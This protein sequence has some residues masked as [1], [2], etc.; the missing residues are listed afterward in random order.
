ME[1]TAIEHG[2]KICNL[3]SK[4]LTHIVVKYS[5][6]EIPQDA[7]EVKNVKVVKQELFWASIQGD[8]RGGSGSSLHKQSTSNTSSLVNQ[9]SRKRRRDTDE[10]DEILPANSLSHAPKRKN[11]DILSENSFPASLPK[12]TMTFPGTRREDSS[13]LEVQLMSQNMKV[14][15]VTAFSPPNAKTVREQVASE[16]LQTEQNY[17]KK[18][19]TILNFKSPLEKIDET[20]G[21]ILE[22][23]EI[24]TTFGN[25]PD[26]KKVH[27]EIMVELQNLL[28]FWTEDKCIGKVILKYTDELRTVYPKY[29]NFFDMRRESVVQCDQRKPRFHAFL[30]ICRSKHE[31][32]R[33]TLA[34]L[35]ILPVQRLPRMNLLLK[36][37]LK[38]TRKAD[39]NNPDIA[40][41]EKAIA[42]LESVITHINECKR[43]SDGQVQMFEIMGDIENCPP[44]ILAAHRSLVLKIDGFEISDEFGKK[45]QPV[46]LFL[47]NDCLEVTKRH[48]KSNALSFLKRDSDGKKPYDHLELIPLSQL[49]NILDITEQ[50]ENH[51]LFG[52]MYE[53]S[54]KI[55]SP[56]FRLDGITKEICL[57]NFFNVLAK[58]G[59]VANRDECIVKVDADKLGIKKSDLSLTKSIIRR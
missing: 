14:T 52:F 2:G 24:K 43:E 1:K 3:E 30:E 22:P 51:D 25:L 35:L 23:V 9:N 11:N 45:A 5:D 13:R 4:K 6:K 36:E 8:A 58:A 31:C 7:L 21:P 20:D 26:I 28:R 39:L 55:K 50:D 16:L 29:I 47:F 54:E 12:Y 10:V 59:K 27:H 19:D 17:V 48:S 49:Q 57:D 40:H 41:L 56:K 34:E 15:P 37:L 32:D 53:S 33:Q 46:T 42:A 18:I 44:N 38:E